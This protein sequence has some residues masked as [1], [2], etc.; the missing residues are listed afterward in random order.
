[1]RM[2]GTSADPR[3]LRSRK[4]NRSNVRRSPLTEPQGV[5][6]HWYAARPPQDAEI[7]SQALIA[8]RLRALNCH[9]AAGLNSFS[10]GSPTNAANSKNWRMLQYSSCGEERGTKISPRGRKDGKRARVAGALRH[11]F[12]DTLQRHPCWRAALSELSTGVQDE[13]P[14]LAP[15]AHHLRPV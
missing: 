3:S 2:P 7:L 1:M 9:Y 6:A 10:S 8:P 5:S 14:M 4:P 11:D 12:D 13:K 15:S